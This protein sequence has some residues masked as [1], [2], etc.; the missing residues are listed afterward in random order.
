MEK[1]NVV[2][3]FNCVKAC[4]VGLFFL[5]SKGFGFMDKEQNMLDKSVTWPAGKYFGEED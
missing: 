1:K 3:N 5:A 4:Y 2:W